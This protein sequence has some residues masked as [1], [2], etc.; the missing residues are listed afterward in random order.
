[1]SLD[2]IVI[3]S[4]IGGL[5]AGALLA[6]YGKRVLV[7][8]SHAIAGGAAHSFSRQGFHFDSGP[9]FYCGLTPGRGLNPLQQVLEVLGESLQAVRYDPMGHYHFPEGTF[10]VYSDAERYCQTV[11]EITPQG[12]RELEQFEKRL[13]PLYESLRE[14]PTIALRADWQIIPVVLRKYLPSVL[15]LLPH[16]KTVQGSVGNVMDREVREPWVRRLIDLECFLLSGL[17]AHGTIAPEVAF[18][19]G[20]RSRAGVEYPVGGSG[21]IVDALVRG[22]KR[23]GGELKLNA[24][25][26][27][28]LIQLGKVTGVKLKNGEIINAPIVISNATIWDTYTK[29]LR[30]EDLP[31]SYRQQSLEMPAVDSFMHLHLGI[32]AEGLENLTGHHVVVHDASKDITEPGNTCMISIPSVWDAN[33]APEGHHVVHAY[34]LEPYEGWQR[35]EG[36]EERKKERSQSLF[37][38]LERVIPDIRDRV[39]LELIGTPLTHAYYLRRYQGTYG[40]AIAAGQGTFPGTQTPISGLYRVGDSTMPGIGVPA[41]AASG[42]LCANTLVTPQETA[43]LLKI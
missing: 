36:Y 22:L 41:V 11:A 39:V 10:P 9:S 30:P 21:A 16:L 31:P 43:K 28:I 4:G 32:R 7:C 26:E 35:D 18:M 19:L 27:Q 2:V 8:E 13:L 34:T 38:A 25:V 17:K 33:L 40:P 5:T 42:I 15:K 20:E 12:A 1:M 3:G 14:I 6:R 24:Q 37:R 29:L 23:W